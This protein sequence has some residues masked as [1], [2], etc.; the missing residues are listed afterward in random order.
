MAKNPKQTIIFR[1][2]EF[3]AH[4]EEADV[5]I[6]HQIARATQI[7]VKRINVVCEDTDVYVLLH[8]VESAAV[9]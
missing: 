4:H 2:K 8:Q 5:I 6:T 1:R 3:M 9:L 7:E